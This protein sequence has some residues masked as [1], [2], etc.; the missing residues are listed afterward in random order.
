MAALYSLVLFVLAAIWVT[1]SALTY[2]LPLLM[3]VVQ[4]ARKHDAVTWRGALSDGLRG[5]GQFA[6]SLFIWGSLPYM[7]I[8]ILALED[9][10]EWSNL[11]RIP[12][13]AAIGV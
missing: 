7:L 12:I 10:S 9:P 4:V 1:I 5:L 13:P 3:T 8:R 2:S 6:I 11:W